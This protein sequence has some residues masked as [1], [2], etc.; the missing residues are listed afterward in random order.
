MPSAVARSARGSPSR[1]YSLATP[2]ELLELSLR[3][4]AP[5]KVLSEDLWRGQLAPRRL[6]IE[7]RTVG[8]RPA[9]PAQRS[10]AGHAGTR[11]RR[12]A[13][14]AAHERAP[15]AAPGIA[16]TQ[17]DAVARLDQLASWS[18]WVPFGEALLTAP[19]VPGVYVA[20]EGAGAV[21]L[22]VGMAGERR[23]NGIRGRL[24]V[25]ASG[26]ALATGLGEAVT[27]RALADADWLAARLAD[28]QAG[29]PV[30][31][32]E[33]GRLAFAPADLH[34]RWTTT[35]TRADADALER[36]CL[37]ALADGPLWNRRRQP[38]G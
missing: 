13:A 15:A 14:V 37:A 7:H 16:V 30:C 12:M 19:R 36:K 9:P 22:Y 28:V 10:C 8:R 3:F 24:P 27:D 2:I 23:G 6:C 33:W 31:A 4:P 38:K 32:K 5:T 1:S 35:T 11:S 20:A 17:S 26:R 29:A 21:V 18:P 25:Y 34:V